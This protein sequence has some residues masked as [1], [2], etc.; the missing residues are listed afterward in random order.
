MLFSRN[1][2]EMTEILKRS[3]VAV[4]GCGGLGSNAA[5]LLT[6]CGIGHLILAD[7][8]VVEP[9]NLNRQHFFQEDIGRPK[10]EALATQLLHINPEIRLT[11]HQ[12]RLTA[13]DI[14]PL[15]S[16]AEVLVEAFDAAAAKTMLLE[17]WTAVF[18]ERLYVGASGLAG[19]G[20]SESMQ[21]RRAGMVW[22]VGDGVSDMAL[23]LAAPRVMLAAALEANCVVEYL[24]ETK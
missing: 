22:M 20:K 6:R 21:V 15:F 16:T 14:A 7:F 13:E 19:Y 23:G 2:P 1:V 12:K 11:C 3:T 17:A 10:V 24:M 4:A 5:M 18:P 9:S 8:D